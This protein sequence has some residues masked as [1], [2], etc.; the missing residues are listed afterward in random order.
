M[1]VKEVIAQVFFGD[2]SKCFFGTNVIYSLAWRQGIMRLN[3]LVII[4]LEA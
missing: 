2:E 4:R 1:R 3:T